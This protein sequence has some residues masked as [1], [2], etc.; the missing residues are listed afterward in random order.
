MKFKL[1]IILYVETSS[2]RN[3]VECTPYN[4]SDPSQYSPFEMHDVVI[5]RSSV[6]H[7]VVMTP[8]GLWNYSINKIIA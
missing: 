3:D 1:F 4:I 8:V 7:R 6:L 5:T 2:N